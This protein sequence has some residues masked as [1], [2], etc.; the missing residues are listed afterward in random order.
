MTRR[1][2]LTH[3]TAYAYS[4]PVTFDP[5][6]LRFRL[7]ETAYLSVE[8]HV[9]DV[10]PPPAG[11]RAM[12]DEENNR[13][14][15]AWFTGAH[16][17]LVLRAQTVFATAADYNP[18]GFVVQPPRFARVPFGYGVRQRASLAPYLEPLSLSEGL[19]V[20]GADV[21]AESGGDTVGFL[22][23]L[24]TRVHARS[25]VIYRETGAPMA[26]AQTYAQAAGSCRDLSWMLIALL[27]HFGIAARFTSG[28]FYLARDTDAGY[29][30]HAWAEAFVPGAGWL[31]LDPSHGIATG[32][33]HFP[34][35]S[36]AHY[37]G[38][39]PV[40]G[41]IRG[42]ATATLTTHVAI[43]PL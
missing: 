33:A 37:S 43:T 12:R 16:Q 4:A 19:Q 22:L 18:L 1:Y 9:L 2:R 17:R 34:V 40:S 23:A 13:A 10:D 3:D 28:Y 21:L 14:A 20:F 24:T 7:R 26:P 25:T 35:C 11:R 27:R 39:M 29:D 6:H 32:H 38:T 31:G 42:D 5:Q 30:L 41:D 15:L 8:S 36:S